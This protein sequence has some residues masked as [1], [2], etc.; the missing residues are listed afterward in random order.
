MS[1]RLRVASTLLALTLSLASVAQP[2]SGALEPPRERNTPVIEA[3]AALRNKPTG[4]FG[5]LRYGEESGDLSGIEIFIMMGL[6]GYVAVVQI[7]EG[8]PAD[9]VVV[10]VTLEGAVV[11]FEMQS[12]KETLRY[13]GTVRA[14]GLYGRFDNAAFSG[15]EDGF[16]LLRRGQSYWQE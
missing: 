8:A 1:R 16:F 11:S 5:R 7:A 9:P 15:R 14:D 12:G 13:K 3:Q 10:P 2:I 6:S 4:T